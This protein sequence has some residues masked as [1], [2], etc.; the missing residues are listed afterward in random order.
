MDFCLKLQRLKLKVFINTR[1][2][3]RHY[4]GAS[5]GK[6][7]ANF[8]RYYHKNRLRCAI[9]NLS[10]AEFFKRFIPAEARWLREKATHDQRIA[11]FYAYSLNFVFLIYNLIVKIKNSF[12]R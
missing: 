10:P 11:I 8:Y 4:E 12:L 2:V 7:S 1:S 3:A 5:V 9:I 6:F